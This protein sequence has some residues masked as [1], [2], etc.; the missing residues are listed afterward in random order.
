MNDGVL[1]RE[2]LKPKSYYSGYLLT[3]CFCTMLSN[4]LMLLIA[5]NNKKKQCNLE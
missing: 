4:A 5:V 2:E 1:L 3:K